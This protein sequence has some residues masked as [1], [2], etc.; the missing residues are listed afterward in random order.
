ML[1]YDS[2]LDVCLKEICIYYSF[3]LCVSL[4]RGDVAA[5]KCLRQ[6]YDG[7][8]STLD[9]DLHVVDVRKLTNTYI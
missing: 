8:I 7:L 2:I 5:Y 6:Q 1:C 3:W 9:P 4:C